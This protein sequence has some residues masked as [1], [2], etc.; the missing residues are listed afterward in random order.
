MVVP[1]S[2]PSPADALTSISAAIVEDLLLP[3]VFLAIGGF[4][5]SVKRECDRDGCRR[6]AGMVAGSRVVSVLEVEEC[7]HASFVTWGAC[8]C[9]WRVLLSCRYREAISGAIE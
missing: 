4:F 7:L 2:E 3:V 9:E 5:D 1:G 6:G 8:P